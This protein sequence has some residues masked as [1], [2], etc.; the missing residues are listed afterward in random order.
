MVVDI[1]S[2]FDL[3]VSISVEPSVRAGT[4]LGD[5]PERSLAGNDSFHHY[6]NIAPE[7]NTSRH[8]LAD[9]FV[10]DCVED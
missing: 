7:Y 5:P 3:R 1:E 9:F 8:R 2:W 6:V 4:F 10:A